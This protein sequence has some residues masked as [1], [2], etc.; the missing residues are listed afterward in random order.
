MAV[1]KT[2]S[3]GGPV[4]KLQE[5]LNKAGA[6]PKLNADGLFGPLTTEAVKAFQKKNKL[7]ADGKVGPNTEAALGDG[8]GGSAGG[9]GAGARKGG[10]EKGKCAALSSDT[11]K[12]LNELTSSLFD[13]WSDCCDAEDGIEKAYKSLTGKG[14][15]S[16]QEKAKHLKP[17]TA[18]FAKTE[19]SQKKFV[20]NVAGTQKLIGEIDQKA[21]D[22]KVKRL[23]KMGQTAAASGK[24][25]ASYS[26]STKQKSEEFLRTI[27][28]DDRRSVKSLQRTY[29]DIYNGAK[30][31]LKFSNAWLDFVEYVNKL[32]KA[33]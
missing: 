21:A 12:K 19:N 7:K 10:G 3:K 32:D 24:G 8:K 5:Q 23:V 11:R 9:G 26:K 20:A 6:K 22:R 31:A 30:P 2:G 18:L 13:H 4:K 27:A 16:E 1:L 14:G 28:N 15:L 17:L 25:F 33:S 29:G